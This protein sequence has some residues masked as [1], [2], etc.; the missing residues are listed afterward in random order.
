MATER[1]CFTTR[2]FAKLL[3]RTRQ[4]DS[5]AD[6]DPHPPEPRRKPTLGELERIAEARLLCSCR[7]P[8]SIRVTLSET[9]VGVGEYKLSALHG[10]VRCRWCCA[11]VT[12]LVDSVAMW[13][14][15]PVEVVIRELRL[16]LGRVRP[17]PPELTPIN[18]RAS[19]RLCSRC[20]R[21]HPHNHPHLVAQRGE[22]PQRVFA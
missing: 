22:A 6:P 13:H 19:T 18:P 4:L 2:L 7:R 14:D 12:A 9:H 8:G 15:N 16:S 21:W 1:V 17:D 11:S 3:G 5:W 10:V 20:R